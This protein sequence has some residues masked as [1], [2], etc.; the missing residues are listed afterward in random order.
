[1]SKSFNYV[2]AGIDYTENYFDSKNTYINE[3]NETEFYGLNCQNDSSQSDNKNI[4]E[5]SNLNKKRRMFD[6]K[7]SDCR[8]AHDKFDLDNIKRKILVHFFKF[9]SNFINKIIR[10]YYGQKFELIP[11]IYYFKEYKFSNEIFNSIKQKKLRDLFLDYT[12][13]KTM[14]SYLKKDLNQNKKIYSEKDF[15]E[16]KNNQKDINKDINKKLI[17]IIEG[18]DIIKD[19]LNTRGFEFFEIYYNNKKIYEL[20]KGKRILLNGLFFYEHLLNSNNIN[21][22]DILFKNMEICAQI[23][24]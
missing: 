4:E 19:I 2:E 5:N 18:N 11:I 21:E 20:S 1:M 22:K 15:T 6:V 13:S 9:L 24:F 12:S 14:N 7:K 10:F 16:N 23:F 3:T 17:E 8:K